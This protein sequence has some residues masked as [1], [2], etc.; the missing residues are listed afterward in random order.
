MNLPSKF[1]IAW[2]DAYSAAF[3]H[4]AN[5]VRD[6]L[7]DLEPEKSKEQRTMML[8]GIAKFCEDQPDRL[9]KGPVISHDALT[10]AGLENGEKIDTRLIFLFTAAAYMSSSFQSLRT[11]DEAMAMLKLFDANY[12]FGFQESGDLRQFVEEDAMAKLVVSERASDAAQKKAA[13]REPARAR[14]REMVESKKWSSREVAKREV[15]EAIL[16]DFPALFLDLD[17]SY[18]FV[19]DVIAKM[20]NADHL[21]L[22]K[23]N[24]KR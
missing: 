11:G 18:R 13:I 16:K 21:F 1:G 22:R 15:S 3:L 14:A 17:K 24:R 4:L 8:E 5:Q 9:L 6:R 20:P 10:A 2:H 19:Q 23:S 12:W 7:D